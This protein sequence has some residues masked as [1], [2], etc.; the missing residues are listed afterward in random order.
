VWCSKWE[1]LDVFGKEDIR[2]LLGGEFRKQLSIQ[3]EHIIGK[4]K[5]L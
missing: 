2:S 3:E 4:W 1:T 5:E